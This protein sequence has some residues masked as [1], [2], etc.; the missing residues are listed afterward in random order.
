MIIASCEEM[1]GPKHHVVKDRVTGK[2]R[3]NHG[4]W[5]YER[6]YLLF[7]YEKD[8]LWFMLK[9]GELGKYSN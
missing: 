1:F 9:Y 3:D 2:Q 4:N 7:R 6:G 5:D 8:Y